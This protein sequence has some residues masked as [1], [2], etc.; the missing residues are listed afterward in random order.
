MKKHRRAQHRRPPEP[1]TGYAPLPAVAIELDAEG[2]QAMIAAERAAIRAELSELIADQLDHLHDD[3]AVILAH[4][5]LTRK[6]CEPWM[7]E[8][9]DDQP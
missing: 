5:G 1:G 7:P 6:E 3:L 9:D 2:E 8:E 4:L